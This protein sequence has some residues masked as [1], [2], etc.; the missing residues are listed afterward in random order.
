MPQRDPTTRRHRAARRVVRAL[1][2]VLIL[3]GRLP[4]PLR[5]PLHLV[6]AAALVA[7]CTSGTTWPL[8][9]AQ[10]AAAL[11]YLAA[12]ERARTLTTA[13]QKSAAG[14]AGGAR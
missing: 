3:F 8:S 13:R 9:M 10:I 6:I 5:L 14:P 2:R 7:G 12:L 1:D 4:Y 11:G